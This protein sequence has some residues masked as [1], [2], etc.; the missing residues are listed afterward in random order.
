MRRKHKDIFPAAALL[1]SLGGVAL[2]YLFPFLVSV[3]YAFVDNPIQMKF[4]G[5][6]N[7]RELFGNPFFL[8][9]MKN[10]LIFMGFAL[11]LGMVC[12]LAL[13]LE[14][15]RLGKWGR[16]LSVIFL[17]PLVM[18]SAT[19][20]GFL[21][22]FHRYRMMIILL[23]VWKYLGYHT[24]LFLTGLYG[25]PEEYYECAAV[26]GAKRRQMFF[27]ITLVY[28]TPSFFLVFMMSFVNS[29]KIFREIYLLQ[30]DSP[31]K[32]VYL[33]QHF[34]NNTMLSMNYQRLVSAVYVLTLLIALVILPTF[35]MERKMAENLKM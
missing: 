12:S 2:F 3:V 16:L 20:V 7:F 10:T 5:F 17:I 26:L 32:H 30:G 35:R 15:K 6:K 13:A 1:A 27:H 25:I 34:V 19:I 8:L 18:P 14:L 22:N 21:L 29:F 11:P 31:D 24:I 9:G 28:L 4:V 33:M 23:Y